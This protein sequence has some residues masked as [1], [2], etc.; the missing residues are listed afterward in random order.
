[1]AGRHWLRAGIKHWEL[2]HLLLA[3]CLCAL[4]NLS[5]L[6]C[7]LGPKKP[8]TGLLRDVNNT[9]GQLKISIRAGR[10]KTRHLKGTASQLMDNS[11]LV[12][13]CKNSSCLHSATYQG[14]WQLSSFLNLSMGR[15]ELLWWLKY[16]WTVRAGSFTFPLCCVGFR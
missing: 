9:S 13:V 15:D 7:K 8:L 14:P 1:M 16:S 12:L 2:G 6:L 11:K 4:L 3:L 10:S 5:F